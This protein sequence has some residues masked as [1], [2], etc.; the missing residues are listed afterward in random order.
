MMTQENTIN[1]LPATM[2]AMVFE[3]AGTALVFKELSRPEPSAEQVL[4]KVIA[5]GVCRTDLHIIDGELKHPNLP[6]VIG[7][8]VIG[9]V[10]KAG[11]A[12]SRLKP[13]DM[14]GVPWLAYA[15]GHCKYCKSGKE[16]LC[17]NAEFTGYTV[18]GGYAEYMVA[19]AAYSFRLPDNYAGAE[20]APLLCA[21]L[22]GFRSY[23]M[24]DENSKN[25][26]LYGFGA[27][28]SILVQVAVQQG[29]KVFAFTRP[30]DTTG[31]DFA[32]NL[33][34][35][36]AGGTDEQAPEKLDA[37]ILFA[38][39]GELVPLALRAVDKGGHVICG[40][41]H[42]SDIPAFSYDLLW[43]ERVL[44]SVANLTRKDGTDFFE[45]LKKIPVHTETTF[46]KLSEA[47]DALNQ[48]RAGKIKGAAVLVMP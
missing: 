3:K 23:R 25:I 41:I 12:V 37:A 15:C 48:L 46:F 18:N 43:E 24:A 27:A 22:I 26:G 10:V 32:K 47:N 20:A 1:S 34:A 38:P 11:E 16:N 2:Q 44:Q 29:K 7:H 30:G 40:G 17:E 13:G 33:G 14:V 42:M 4:I 21:G 6:L 31:Q 45:L 19:N 9:K 28:A 36:W 35:Y 8:E 39:A 5:C